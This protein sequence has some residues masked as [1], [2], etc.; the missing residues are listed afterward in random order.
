MSPL[1][2][3]HAGL[4]ERGGTL[5]LRQ[6]SDKWSLRPEHFKIAYGCLPPLDEQSAIVRFVDHVDRSMRR[7]PCGL[8]RAPTNVRLKPSG[9]EWLGE[10]CMYLRTGMCSGWEGSRRSS[11][12]TTFRENHSNSW[13]ACRKSCRQDC[14][15]WPR[16]KQTGP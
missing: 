6:T 5:V 11:I 7:Y 13:A 4:R 15:V 8:D 3:S 14:R 10:I 16:R 2:A 9:F 1:L 12:G